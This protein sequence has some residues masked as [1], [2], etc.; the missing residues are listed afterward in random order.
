MAAK[1][2]TPSVVKVRSIT[3]TFQ[4]VSRFGG[5]HRAFEILLFLGLVATR[6]NRRPLKGSFETLLGRGQHNKRRRRWEEVRAQQYEFPKPVGSGNLRIEKEEYQRTGIMSK[7][8]NSFRADCTAETTASCS[9]VIVNE[10][11]EL[12]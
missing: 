6:Y 5:R 7:S 9:F 3:F 10:F 2:Q 1:V 11:L 4:N 12:C 8:G